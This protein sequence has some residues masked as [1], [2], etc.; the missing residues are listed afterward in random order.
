[1]TNNEFSRKMLT[2]FISST[3]AGVFTDAVVS[4]ASGSAKPLDLTNSFYNGLQLGTNFV[5]YP[6]AT[7]LLENKSKT[8]RQKEKENNKVFL[9]ASKAVVTAG[10]VA[11][12]NY[13]ISKFQEVHNNKKTIISLKDFGIY[14][15]DQILPNVGF[16]VTNDYLHKV[17][18]VPKDSLSQYLRESTIATLSSLGGSV[19]N[20]PL[21]IP[22][23]HATISGTLSGWIKSIGKTTCTNDS[24]AHFAKTLQFITQ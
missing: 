6:I 16:P 8:Y 23:D 19:A 5:A 7:R 12:V 22:K 3:L 17:I 24:Y 4:G 21:S 9:Y 10:I 13:P 1:M 11:A 18:P 2:T 20:L 14:F 15:A